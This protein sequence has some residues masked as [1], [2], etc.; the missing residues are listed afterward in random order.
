MAGYLIGRN[1]EKNEDYLISAKIRD[2]RFVYFTGSQTVHRSDRIFF[3]DLLAV[4]AA[5]G[6]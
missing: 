2:G 3:S 4:I 1:P 5:I 6:D